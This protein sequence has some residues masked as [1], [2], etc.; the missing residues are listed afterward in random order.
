MFGSLVIPVDSIFFPGRDWLVLA[1]ICARV[2]VTI[3]Y[4]TISGLVHRFAVP[5]VDRYSGIIQGR[6][7]SSTKPISSTSLVQIEEANFDER[8]WK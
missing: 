6:K 2:Y 1:W 8:G 4:V 5:Y 7:L 3:L